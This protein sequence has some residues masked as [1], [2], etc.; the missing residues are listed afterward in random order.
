M[1]I[2]KSMN[3]TQFKLSQICLQ[4]IALVIS[5]V[6]FNL[7]DFEMHLSL[8]LIAFL[9]LIN[10]LNGCMMITNKVAVAGKRYLMPIKTKAYGNDLF[11]VKSNDRKTKY[12][13]RFYSRHKK[14]SKINEYS[15]ILNIDD[16]VKSIDKEYL[17]NEWTYYSNK[18]LSMFRYTIGKTITIK[19]K[20]ILKNTHKFNKF[21]L[22]LNEF[23]NVITPVNV[24]HAKPAELNELILNNNYGVID[25]NVG[26]LIY[27]KTIYLPCPELGEFA[28]FKIGMNLHYRTKFGKLLQFTYPVTIIVDLATMPIQLPI[29][30]VERGLR[31]GDL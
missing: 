11:L 2:N 10:S 18:S 28:Y 29:Y 22:Q 16:I 13:I 3:Q 7:R 25:N 8:K 27:Y 4:K 1:S 6:S 23:S 30:I 9:L 26:T 21:D 31:N 20:F 12:L 19:H 24:T 5:G 14:Y 15:F 17:Q